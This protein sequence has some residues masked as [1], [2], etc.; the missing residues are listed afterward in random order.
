MERELTMFMSNDK[1]PEPSLANDRL[2][3]ASKTHFFAPEL[4]ENL[5]EML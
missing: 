2:L 5:V 1:K 4:Q 3:P